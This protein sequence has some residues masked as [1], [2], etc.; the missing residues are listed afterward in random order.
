MSKRVK[1]TQVQCRE[2][3]EARDWCKVN[4]F[5]GF[6]AWYNSSLE[7]HAKRRALPGDATEYQQ[8]EE[9]ERPR[10]RDRR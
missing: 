7:D 9:D 10:G 1:L 4:D 5:T 3:V 6:L 8:F 2:L